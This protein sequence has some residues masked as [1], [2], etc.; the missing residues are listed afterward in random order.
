MV[1]SLLHGDIESLT[2]DTGERTLPN[3][4]KFGGKDNSSIHIIDHHLGNIAHWTLSTVD[5]TGVFLTENTDHA[6]SH[7]SYRLAFSG[8]SV[9]LR[10][11]MPINT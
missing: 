5:A 2:N 11:T 6:H 3:I 8:M 4:E 9:D 7:M 10:Y 1:S